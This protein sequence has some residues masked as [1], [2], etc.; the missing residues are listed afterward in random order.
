MLE[1]V[2]LYALLQVILLSAA[3]GGHS[4]L[5]LLPSVK[6]SWTTSDIS[7]DV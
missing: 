4:N 2:L 5:R 3:T 1:N 7:K 6:S